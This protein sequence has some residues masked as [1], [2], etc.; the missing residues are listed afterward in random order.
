MIVGG[1]AVSFSFLPAMT[2]GD[3]QPQTASIHQVTESEDHWYHHLGL[4]WDDRTIGALCD[5]TPGFGYS[6]SDSRGTPTVNNTDFDDSVCMRF[7]KT[8]TT[9][10]M[11]A[12]FTRTFEGYWQF[13]TKMAAHA[14]NAELGFWLVN[15]TTLLLGVGFAAGNLYIWDGASVTYGSFAIDTWYDFYLR[16]STV[17]DTHQTFIND[18]LKESQPIESCRRQRQSGHRNVVS[19]GYEHYGPVIR[20]R[21]SD[22][23]SCDR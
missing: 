22:L 8:L 18:T 7:N 17:N 9:G 10:G 14:A 13:S 6:W 23:G 1:L 3:S 20:R 4:W 19:F 5:D 2:D 16:V 21:L 12:K 15:G 11:D